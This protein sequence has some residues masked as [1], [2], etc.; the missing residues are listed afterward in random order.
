MEFVPRQET[1]DKVP[2]PHIPTL[3]VFLLYLRA[4]LK[5]CAYQALPW[6]VLR[7]GRR[8]VDFANGTVKTTHT[9]GR[10]SIRFSNGDIK[11]QSPGG[12]VDYF[13]SEVGL[14]GVQSCRMGVQSCRMPAFVPSSVPPAPRTQALISH[15]PSS[16]FHMA[17]AH[18]PLASLPLTQVGTWHT[19]HGQE[20][21]GVEVF[22][23]PGGQTEAHHP[24]GLKEIVFPDGRVRVV[25]PGNGGE[26]EVPRSA[27]SWA[28]RQALPQAEEE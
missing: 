11:M 25:M 7:S 5:F 28:A 17:S 1:G 24:D 15:S 4:S 18:L 14:M 19:T 3:F 10:Q 13:Y 23:F 21:G 20:G 27:L 2:S 6:S 8:R 26:R 9:D 16:A 22:H 12:R